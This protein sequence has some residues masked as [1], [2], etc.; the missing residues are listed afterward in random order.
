M[1][2]LRSDAQEDGRAVW[3]VQ[4]GST[5]LSRKPCQRRETLQAMFVAFAITMVCLLSAA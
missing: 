1:R 5:N 2:G 3:F 4:P